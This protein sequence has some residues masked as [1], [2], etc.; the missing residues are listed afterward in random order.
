MGKQIIPAFPEDVN[1]DDFGHWL[2]G[3]TDA[4]ASFILREQLFKKR[5][6]FYYFAYY[7]ITLRDDDEAT[8]RLIRSYWQCGNLHNA[9]NQRSKIPNA[10]PTATYAVNRVADLVRVVVPHFERF[11]LMA[12][13]RNDFSVWRRGV[14]LMDSVQKR[15]MR[16]FQGHAPG[17]Y[18]GTFPKWTE[19]ER[20]QF[21]SIAAELRGQRQYP[22]ETAFEPPSSKPLKYDEPMLP[23]FSDP[24]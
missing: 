20:E 11:P 7:R 6:R 9:T 22:G 14:M 16:H 21:R 12:K 15:R 2:S 17:Y 5:N 8:L 10:K 18:G 24:T 3:F 4:E 13:K 1:R 23:G 19:S